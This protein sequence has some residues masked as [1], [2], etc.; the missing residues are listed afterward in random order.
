[1]KI[2]FTH[3]RDDYGVPFATVANDENSF[4]VAICGEKDQ[5]ARKIGRCIA[6]GRLRAGVNVVPDS[7]R[8][9]LYKDEPVYAAEVVEL[10]LAKSLS[11]EE[12]QNEESELMVD[13]QPEV[14]WTRTLRWQHL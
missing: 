10:F 2:R 3:L 1:M 12:Y 9:V 8:M 14:V 13:P 5:F 7:P 6:S 4:G 11:L